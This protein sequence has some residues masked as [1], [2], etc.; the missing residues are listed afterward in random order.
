[1]ELAEELAGLFEQPEETIDLGR[2]AL[3]LARSE[4]PEL[5]L[6]EQVGRLDELG[7]RAAR[8]VDTEGPLPER[9]DALRAFLAEQCGFRGNAEDYYDPANSFLNRVLDRRT[10]IPISLSVVYMEVG[11]RVNLPLFGVG[12]PGHF[13]VKCQDHRS[14]IFLDPFHGGRITTPEVCRQIVETMHKRQIAFREDMLAAVEKR[15]IVLRMLHNL[16]GVYLEQRQ[17][18]KALAIEEM[19]LALHPDSAEDWKLRGLLHY[20]LGQSG[21]SRRDLE[22]YLAL[23]P[24]GPDAEQVRELIQDLKRASALRN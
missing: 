20:Q 21:L 4:Y 9:V 2:A 12:L 18:R 6:D 15:Y 10:G 16:R 11:R 17:L 8:S 19:V 13:L 23:R 1:M 5:N 24:L 22:R 7:R 14:R 3:L